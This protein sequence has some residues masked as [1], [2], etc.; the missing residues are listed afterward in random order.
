MHIK[1]RGGKQLVKELSGGNKQKVVF[2][3]WLGTD[4][5]VLIL[6]CPTRGIDV[7]VKADMYKL[8]ME[9]KAQG[10]GIIM[11]SEELL[12]LI[13]MSDRMMIFKDGKLSR[14]FQRSESL[15]EKDIIDYI[16]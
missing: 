1:C 2:S 4:A 7:G 6:D 11:I 3:K 10:K 16:I 12:E 14:E 9:L 8:M 15:S 13:G 5:D